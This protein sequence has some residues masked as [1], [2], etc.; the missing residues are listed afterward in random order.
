[1]PA[2]VMYNGLLYGDYTR[3]SGMTRAD[4]A[5]WRR[6]ED[7]RR[8]AAKQPARLETEAPANIVTNCVPN[9]AMPVTT[10]ASDGCRKPC[11]AGLTQFKEWWFERMVD[12]RVGDVT[13]RG[14][15]LFLRGDTLRVVCDAHSYFIPLSRIDYIRTPNGLAQCGGGGEGDE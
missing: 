4:A 2:G 5:A 13:L 15:P 11:G 1:M 8:T 10:T 9:A 12:I 14:M 6:F 3:V 7:R